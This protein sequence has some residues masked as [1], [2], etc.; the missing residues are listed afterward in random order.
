ML[1][2]VRDA[3]KPKFGVAKLIQRKFLFK[4]KTK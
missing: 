4:K 1:I 2:A 3:F